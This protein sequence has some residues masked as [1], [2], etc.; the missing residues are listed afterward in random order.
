MSAWLEVIAGIEKEWVW[1]VVS[2]G[3]KQ[4]RDTASIQHFVLA[5]LFACYY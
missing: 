1:S 3:K 5:Q 4:S 2:G